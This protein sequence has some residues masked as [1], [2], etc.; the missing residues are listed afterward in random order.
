MKAALIAA[1]V[2]TLV[3]SL[4]K[5]SSLGKLKVPVVLLP[6]V[7]SSTG[8][9]VNFTLSSPQGCFSWS[10]YLLCVCRGGGI[11]VQAVTLSYNQ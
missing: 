1:T 6:Y 10:V 2:L 9:K 11:L 3:C 7:P 4:H 8:V 5:A